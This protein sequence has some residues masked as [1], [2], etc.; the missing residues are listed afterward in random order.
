MKNRSKIIFFAVFVL[1]FLFITTNTSSTKA[2]VNTIALRHPAI[3]VL[4]VQ[5]NAGNHRKTIPTHICSSNDIITKY[6]CGYTQDPNGTWPQDVDESGTFNQYPYSNN[7][8][9]IS[10]EN[11]YL[12]N[13][14][15][16]EMSPANGFGSSALK[17]QTIAARTYAYYF[18]ENS[19]P[20][21]TY[22]VENHV[23]FQYFQA[24]AKYALRNSS[25]HQSDA[26]IASTSGYYL[27]IPSNST[28]SIHSEFSSD[29]DIRIPGAPG[30]YYTLDGQDPAL[31]SV[32]DPITNGEE[33]PLTGP[34]GH[35]RGLSQQGAKKW[36][37]GLNSNNE[38][39]P[40][41]D[42]TKIL[43]HYY[44]GIN[45]Y[46]P[47]SQGG[48]SPSWGAYRWN[49]LTLAPASSAETYY[50]GKA[51]SVTLRIQNT[52]TNTWEAGTTLRYRWRRWS[53]SGLAVTAWSSS[54]SVPVLAPGQNVLLS[55]FNVTPPGSIYAT[56]ACCSYALE[57]DLFRPNG[58]SYQQQSWLTQEWAIKLR[59][60]VSA[61]TAPPPCARPPCPLNTSVFT[62]HWN[63][64]SHVESL[65]Y[66]WRRTSA[67]GTVSGTTTQTSANIPLVSGTNT[68]SVQARQVN[69]PDNSSP[70]TTIG[71]VLYDPD[72]PTLAWATLP[73]W[74]NATSLN[75]SWSGTD[76]LSGIA[77][78]SLEQRIN[79]GAWTTLITNGPATSYAATNLL[80]ATDYTFRLTVQDQAGNQTQFSQ[81]VGID[82][83]PSSGQLNSPAGTLI[84]T[85][86]VLH[87]TTSGDRAPIVVFALDRLVNG[88]WQTLEP[89]ISGSSE[90][91]LFEGQPNTTYALRLRATDAAGNHQPADATPQIT[92]T[93]GADSSGLMKTWLPVMVRNPPGSPSAPPNPLNPY[94]LPPQ[95]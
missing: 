95:R 34:N 59:W 39:F 23:G 90:G 33:E 12:P 15:P 1:H 75:L 21:D 2:E 56:A 87:W 24:N 50:V 35:G 55:A 47:N 46:V 80:A 69:E 91:L 92:F 20:S 82:R 67:Q 27:G 57:W 68:L 77:G 14:V 3:R 16:I 44:T 22:D 7:P 18:I 17:A 52:G 13:V 93:T 32:Y 45:M 25:Y 76:T 53:T 28:Q 11:E 63:S 54:G 9:T 60:P 5:I 51:K 62:A 84:K 37:V 86:T 85:W 66:Q 49:V 6:G 81:T 8:S 64:V 30:P 74:S 31:N 42:Y 43:A 72:P 83:T 41:W 88:T 40:Q 29:H 78:Y 89:G 71:T 79:T 36:G 48:Y 61:P 4:S 94:P 10:V 38:R 65:E 58:N 26:A 73:T 19:A 70:W